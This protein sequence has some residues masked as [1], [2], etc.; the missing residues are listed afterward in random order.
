M[1][2]MP[3]A[4]PTR[5]GVSPRRHALSAS[6]L[7]LSVGHWRCRPVFQRPE[8]RESFGR[9]LTR[10]GGHCAN[11]LAGPSALRLVARQHSR[12]RGQ[13]SDSSIRST[14]NCSRSRALNARAT[15]ARIACEN[16]RASQTRARR[17]SRQARHTA[18][19]GPSPHARRPAPT[20]PARSATACST[21]RR[22][23]AV[24]PGCWRGGAAPPATRVSTCIA[25]KS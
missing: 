20:R 12:Q 3:G 11:H 7:S 13:R 15:P 5:T 17:E 2:A 21:K 8:T 25:G 18:S 22:C 24:V 10:R 14:K 6:S 23:S 1:P 4:G 9:G 16:G 19:R